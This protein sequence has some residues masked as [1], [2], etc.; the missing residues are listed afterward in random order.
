M[1]RK[2]SRVWPSRSICCIPRSASVHGHFPEDL[3][4][5]LKNRSGKIKTMTDPPSSHS[6]NYAT[7]WSEWRSWPARALCGSTN[8]HPLWVFRREL[9]AQRDQVFRF[10]EGATLGEVERAYIDFTLGQIGNNKRR[11]AKMLG[12][13]ERTLHNR[14]AE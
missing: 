7:F 8:S 9:P 10:R 12:V 5:P 11:A 6:G 13:S 4:R 14:L 2:R 3:V 1:N